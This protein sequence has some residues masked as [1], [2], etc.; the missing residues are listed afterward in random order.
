MAT[1]NRQLLKKQAA[2]S[3]AAAPNNPKHILLIHTGVVLLLSLLLTV[4]DFL[5]KKAIENT[6]GLSG[7]GT[8]SVLTT[9]QSLLRLG[10]MVLLPFWQIGYTFATLKFYRKE[11]TLPSDLCIGFRRFLPFLRLTLLQALLYLIIG[12]VSSQAGSF[13]F[14]LTPWAA[15]IMEAI[16]QM[17]YGGSAQGMENAL[18]ALAADAMIPLMVCTAFVFLALS[19]PFFYR[20]RLAQYILLDDPEG[21]AWNAMR[22]SWTW[23]RGNAVA[24]F[25]LDFSFWWFYALDLLSSIIAYA[26]ALLLAMGVT[27]PVSEEFAFFSS[28][29][30]YLLCQLALY[31][32]RRNEVSTT[33]AAFY[34]AAH[35]A[36]EA[37]KPYPSRPFWTA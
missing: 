23:T 12:F 22:T 37:P 11:A 32:W 10:Q 24:L 30:L 33:Y 14:M 25:R 3:L 17:L 20:F 29:I 31:W 36:P 19:I 15:P 35:P 2:E 1:R 4:A 16:T 21:K 9:V 28:F 18:E 7:L 26:D 27:L 5:L 13:L 6:G 8:R 34:H